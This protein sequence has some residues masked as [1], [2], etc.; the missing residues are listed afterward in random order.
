MSVV[1]IVFVTI[2]RISRKSPTAK[3]FKKMIR[4]KNCIY[5][6]FSVTLPSTM[7]SQKTA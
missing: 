3:N 4:R 6:V 1:R 5:L 7:I 2:R